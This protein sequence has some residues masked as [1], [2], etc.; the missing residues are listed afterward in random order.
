[1]VVYSLKLS[2]ILPDKSIKHV[3]TINSDSIL[4]LKDEFNRIDHNYKYNDHKYKYYRKYNNEN[5]PIK[6]SNKIGSLVL[7]YNKKKKKTPSTY[8][9]GKNK[10]FIVDIYSLDNIDTQEE[11]N[12]IIQGENIIQDEKYTINSSVYYKD[13]LMILKLFFNNVRVLSVISSGSE[14]LKATLQNALKMDKYKWVKNEYKQLL[15][16]IKKRITSFSESN[17]SFKSYYIKK[18]KIMISYS[19]NVN[20][21]DN[22]EENTIIEA[23]ST[24]ASSIENIPTTITTTTTNTVISDKVNNINEEKITEIE[25]EIK[26]LQ[27]LID[28]NPLSR[29]PVYTTNPITGEKSYK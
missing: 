24:Q 5:R 11:V 21:L 12:K 6:L 26:T 22:L 23:N 1:M 25:E 17:K 29:I 9:F 3:T 2:Y 14:E 20:Y 27:D 28:T 4:G 10:N 13:N 8:T 19:N 7:D 18:F 15:N 16:D